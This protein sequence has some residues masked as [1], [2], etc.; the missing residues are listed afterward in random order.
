MSEFSHMSLGSSYSSNI[1][2]EISRICASPGMSR[3]RRASFKRTC[4]FVAPN[5]SHQ[6]G[7]S[8]SFTH[9]SLH[10]HARERVL[11]SDATGQI[12]KRCLHAKARWHLAAM[13]MAAL[14]ITSEGYLT[15]R[16]SLKLEEWANGCDAVI[17]TR[18]SG[19]GVYYTHL[20]LRMFHAFC[21]NAESPFRVWRYT[22]DGS[23]THK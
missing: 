14:A 3:R 11:L 23:S 7:F 17:S 1:E 2:A 5:I 21:V 19:C 12:L 6:G 15:Q 13:K 10:T 4:V 22:P 8:G 16:S 20:S 18:A 9:N